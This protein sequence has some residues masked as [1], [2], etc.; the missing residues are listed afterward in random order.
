MKILLAI[1]G[2]TASDRAIELVAATTWPAGSHVELIHVADALLGVYAGMPGVVVSAEAV[3]ADMEADHA[4]RQKFLDEAGARLIAPGRSVATQI[5]DGRPA[6]SI[7]E[8]RLMSSVQLSLM[9]V[10]ASRPPEPVALCSV[11]S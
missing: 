8:A 11:S 4:R 3:E 7:V 9:V 10:R 6:S 5:I 1:D 2:S